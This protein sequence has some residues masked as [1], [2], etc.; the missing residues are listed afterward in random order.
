LAEE[1]P[2]D[3]N[4]AIVDPHHHLWEI[5]PA[6][7][8][9]HI[10][11]RF[12]LPELLETIDRSGHNV[13]HTVF[14][15]CHAMYRDSG[16]DELRPIGE[17]EF[18]NGIAAMS[19]SG[20]YGRCRV[21]AG[22]VGSANPR[23]GARITPILEALR[24]AGGGRFRGVRF[25]TAYSEGGMFGAPPDTTAKGLMREPKFHE[26]AAVLQQMG[27]SLDVWC[28]HTQLNEVLELAEAFP[29]LKIILDHLGTPEALGAY[30][31]REAEVRAEWATRIAKLARCPNIVVKLGG[32]GM[33]LAK[34]IGSDPRNATSTLLAAQW[35]PYIETCIAAFTPRRCMFES[36]FPPDSASGT[37]GAIWNAF[38]RITS[39]YSED[40]KTA[41]FSSTAKK[42]Y[43]LE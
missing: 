36:N 5:R 21:A 3:S 33:N 1:P 29:N 6:P 18:A 22:I 4:R 32:L 14:L 41:L 13:T 28:F 16:P 25:M 15:E 7:G 35:L 34:S 9:M 30:A 11:Q 42:V 26:A 23:L 2:L 40:E 24:V 39:D 31:G 8:A 19:A 37:Y 43:R 12:L 27:L 20:G 38:K 17:V 10:A